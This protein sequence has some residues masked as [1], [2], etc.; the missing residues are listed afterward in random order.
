[1]ANEVVSLEAL[2]QVIDFDLTVAGAHCDIAGSRIDAKLES[3][4]SCEP[5]SM[6]VLWRPLLWLISLWVGQIAHAIGLDRVVLRR[7]DQYLLIGRDSKSDDCFILFSKLAHGTSCVNMNQRH[8]LV[9]QAQSKSTILEKQES[10]S[11][12]SCREIFL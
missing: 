1:M 7:G 10:A 11:C 4:A 9:F 2:L 6:E 12:V 5:E 8:R 3:E